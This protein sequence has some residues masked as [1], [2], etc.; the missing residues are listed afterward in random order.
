MISKWFVAVALLWMTSAQAVEITGQVVR[1]SDGD[2]F[3]LRAAD[4]RGIACASMESMRRSG[5]SQIGK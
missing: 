4:G 5:R 2:S 3:A 1:V